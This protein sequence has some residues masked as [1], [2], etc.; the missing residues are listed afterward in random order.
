LLRKRLFNVSKERGERVPG[1][2]PT[3]SQEDLREQLEFLKKK[4][5][6]NYAIVV[7]MNLTSQGMTCN[8]NVDKLWEMALQEGLRDFEEYPD[9]LSIKMSQGATPSPNFMGQRNPL[10]FNV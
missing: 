2:S 1:V 9:W 5:F 10:L 4:Y 6:A 3:E 8:M 7:K